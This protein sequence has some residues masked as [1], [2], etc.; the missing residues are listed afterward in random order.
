MDKKKK[1]LVVDDDNLC[2]LIAEIMLRR[3]YE[4]FTAQ[5]GNEALDHFLTG[6]F[7]DLI[8]L[9]ILMPNMDGWETYNKIRGISLLKDIPIV[10]LTSVSESEEIKRAFS[11]GAVDY[12]IKPYKYYKTI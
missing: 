7:P 10:F 4:I 2:L 5:S 11:M 9:D 8:L 1:I 6:L 3:E 12:I